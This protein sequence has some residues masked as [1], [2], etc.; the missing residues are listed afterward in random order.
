MAYSDWVVV[1]M[2]LAHWNTA[3]WEE[4]QRV[5]EAEKMVS[6]ATVAKEEGGRVE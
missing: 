4:A 2:D 5:W 1:R 6:T 3:A